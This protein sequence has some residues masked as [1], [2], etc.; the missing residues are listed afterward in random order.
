MR[1]LAAAVTSFL[2]L[3][4]PVLAQDVPASTNTG[5]IHGTVIDSRTSQPLSGATVRL[6][7]RG[8][9][10][11]KSASTGADG[12]FVFKGL[13]PGRYG[14]RASRDG[15]ASGPRGEGSG[16][17][18]SSWVAVGGGQTVDDIVIRLS[19]T[20]IIAGR[21]TNEREEPMAQVF[22]QAMR[23]SYHDG[24][25]TLTTS[26][27]AF[28]D[29]HGEFR[30]TDLP[31]G[32]YCVK[33]T[34]PRDSERKTQTQVYV[35][36]FYPNV[37]DP[38]QAQ[39]VDLYSGDELSG[40]RFTLAPVRSVHVKGRVLISGAKPA[41]GANVTL[42]QFGSNGL[43]IEAQT[44]KTGKFDIAGVSAGTYAL[45][46]QWSP[47][48]ESEKVLVGF[49]TITVGETDLATPDV[50]VYPETTVS[51]HVAIAANSKVAMPRSVAY[52]MAVAGGG[53]AVSSASVQPD[54][55]FTFQDVPEGRYRVRLS[56]LPAGYYAAA[57]ETSVVVS[58]GSAGSVE[59]P[60]ESG[61]GQIRGVI[62]R[63]EDKQVPA[64]S[65][66]V[67]LLPEAAQQI[68]GE[69]LRTATTD[70]S[71]KFS[72]Q[73]L[74]PGEY[75]VLAFDT[76]DRDRYTDPQFLEQYKDAGQTVRIENAG[77][78]DLQLLL[79]SLPSGR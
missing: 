59:F 5:S 27:S 2:F 16:R 53:G 18:P 3:A 10:G 58:H 6:F 35:P 44:D 26:R 24:E 43:Q 36:L 7:T 73:S 22:V 25:L 20:G 13:T 42:S 47:T 49:E 76:A 46:A 71:G 31:P 65:A 64:D 61:A 4:W 9:G 37:T 68:N 19:P 30:I 54:G 79:T 67:V 1:S 56:S 15:Y 39:P 11:A 32:Q 14:I 17:M 66:T 52:L 75:S 29:G 62:Y 70:R 23:R 45:Q 12:G 51:G 34:E 33:A 77:S 74:P 60:L 48:Q 50:S 41:S 38:A 78:L 63:D 8:S 55:S 21:I 72:L 69:D 28:T 57:G 40:I